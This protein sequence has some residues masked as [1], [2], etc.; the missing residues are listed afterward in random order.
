MPVALLLLH[1]VLSTA[2]D[3]RKIV[4]RF[5]CTLFMRVMVEGVDVDPTPR[6]IPLRLTTTGNVLCNRPAVPVV[7]K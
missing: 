5:I 3:A 1:A 6:H 7:V 4:K 2:S